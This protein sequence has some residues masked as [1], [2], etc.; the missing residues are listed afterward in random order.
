MTTRPDSNPRRGFSLIEVLMAIFILGIGVISIAALFPAGIAQQRQSTDD[1]MGPIVANNAMA[2]LR[3]KLEQEDFGSF[4]DF[5]FSVPRPTI[6]GDWSWMRPAFI[7]PD[8]APTLYPLGAIDIFNGE[9]TGYAPESAYESADPSILMDIPFNTRRYGY[10]PLEPPTFIITQQERYY[11]QITK[12]AASGI[13]S[14]PQYVW[15][16]MFRRFQGK[17]QVA[18]FV[19]RVTSAGGGSRTYTVAPPHGPNP[20]PPLPI[21]LDLTAPANATYSADGRWDSTGPNEPP[22]PTNSDN[23]PGS[24]DDNFVHGFNGATFDVREE[25]QAWQAAG[26]WIVDQHGDVHRVLSSSRDDPGMPALVELVR[27]IVPK[28]AA[29]Y[30]VGLDEY[31]YQ[32]VYYAPS[33]V[34]DI[35]YLPTVVEYPDGTDAQLTPV[36]VTVKEL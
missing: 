15:D 1:V 33:V 26:Q 7:F 18:I 6:P 12:D 5:G 9:A 22:G 29:T 35:W 3:A 28:S 32:R 34:T 19:Y 2:V 30:F 25:P 14:K 36:Y 20:I 17:V 10:D 31:L 8:A 13:R 11:P 16:C 21:W 24:G 27:P 4:E 23:G